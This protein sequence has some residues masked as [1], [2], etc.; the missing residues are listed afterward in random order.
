MRLLAGSNGTPPRAVAKIPKVGVALV[1]IVVLTRELRDEVH[2]PLV[3]SVWQRLIA[4]GKVAEP[5]FAVAVID[6]PAPT[7]TVAT[8]KAFLITHDPQPI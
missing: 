2:R 7:F 8:A 4:S 1:L 5:V 3:G 6:A